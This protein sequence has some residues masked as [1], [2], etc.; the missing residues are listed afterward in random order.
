MWPSFIVRLRYQFLSFYLST[1]VHKMSMN[2][3]RMGNTFAVREFGLMNHKVPKDSLF[4][5]RER[6]RDRQTDRQAGR[7]TEQYVGGGKDGL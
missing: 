7:H 2:S 1:F 5:Q 3:L 4:H 6:P